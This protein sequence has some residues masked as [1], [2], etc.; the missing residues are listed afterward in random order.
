M[1]LGVRVWGVDIRAF[2]LVATW[3]LGPDFKRPQRIHGPPQSWVYSDGGRKRNGKS[4]SGLVSSL[5]WS[6]FISEVCNC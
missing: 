3:Q 1:N 6:G 5:R 4:R 2:Q